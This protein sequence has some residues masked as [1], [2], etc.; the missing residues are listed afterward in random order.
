MCLIFDK[1]LTHG[2]KR[3]A[4]QTPVFCNILIV[5]N[6]VTQKKHKH[7]K[8]EFKRKIQDHKIGLVIGFCHGNTGFIG[9]FD[10]KYYLYMFI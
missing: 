6:H 5:H 10:I 2:C 8:Q 7:D 9:L 4:S 1:R 3:C